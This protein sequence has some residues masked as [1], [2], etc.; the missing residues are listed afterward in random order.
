METVTAITK[1][2][3]I[4]FLYTVALADVVLRSAPCGILTNHDALVSNGIEVVYARLYL[5]ILGMTQLLVVWSKPVVQIAVG[6]ILAYT[7]CKAYQ[8]LWVF[9]LC[10]CS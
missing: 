2:Y 5:W 1:R 6:S 8:Q 4:A 9:V 3:N 7:V 10:V